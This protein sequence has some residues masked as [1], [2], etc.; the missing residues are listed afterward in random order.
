MQNH[1]LNQNGVKL[2]TAAKTTDVEGRL[3]ALLQET[4]EL[5][6]E[7]RKMLANLDKE[8][9][10]LF[11]L[12]EDYDEDKAKCGIA[13]GID[14]DGALIVETKLETLHVVSGEVSVRGLYGYV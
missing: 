3:S 4:K 2:L 1:F 13:R 6:N 9:K 10:V 11:G 14:K 5:K 8:V 12:A 7:I